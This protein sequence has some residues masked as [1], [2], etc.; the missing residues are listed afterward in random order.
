MVRTAK[1]VTMMPRVRGILA[2][3]G[4]A[5]RV[6]NSAIRT[7]I[8]VGPHHDRGKHQQGPLHRHPEATCAAARSPASPP[9]PSRIRMAAKRTS[10][11]VCTGKGLVG[12]SL[13]SRVWPMIYRIANPEKGGQRSPRHPAA[14]TSWPTRERTGLPGAGR[15]TGHRPGLPRARP[16]TKMV[17]R[18]VANPIAIAPARAKRKERVIQVNRSP[19][20]EVCFGSPCGDGAQSR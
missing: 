7:P 1:N 10:G 2:T 20:V 5:E 13:S 8:L 15:R 3:A 16:S 18:S 19:R 9:Y 14:G 12:R 6:R 4:M 17:K 11:R